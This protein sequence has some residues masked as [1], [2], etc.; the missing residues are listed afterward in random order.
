MKGTGKQLPKP[1]RGFWLAVLF[2]VVL[3]DVILAG[4]GLM[5][6]SE[7]YWTFNMLPLD[8]F[9][10]EFGLTA[11]SPYLIVFAFFALLMVIQVKSVEPKE[12]TGVV[13][14]FLKKSVQYAIY[15]LLAL[16]GI[17]NLLWIFFNREQYA[18]FLLALLIYGIF[19]TILKFYRY[20]RNKGEIP[21]RSKKSLLIVAA[22][23]LVVNIL[24]A[25]NVTNVSSYGVVG[26][27]N[28]V[29]G[30]S[31]VYNRDGTIRHNRDG[32]IVED[33]E[34]E[35]RAIHGFS[36]NYFLLLFPVV[37]IGVPYLF[38]HPK[39]VLETKE[40]NRPSNERRKKQL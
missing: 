22:V 18:S 19:Y 39:V 14:G 11:I 24:F 20:A 15:Y 7:D 32:S 6:G 5:L 35:R 4:K 26:Y 29:T 2:C 3:S 21:R 34:Y 30:W 23:C 40:E 13:L 37:S 25:R 27:E 1:K 38:F 12:R 33:I 16:L 28:V 10:A 17:A 8:S 31:T 36:T 9:F